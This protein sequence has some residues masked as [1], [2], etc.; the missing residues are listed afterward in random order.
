VTDVGEGGHLEVLQWARDYD[1]QWKDWNGGFAACEDVV[2]VG[3]SFP[4]G[5]CV[6]L[7]I[8][9]SSAD[10]RSNTREA[11]SLMYECFS[12]AYFICVSR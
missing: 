1:C 5:S 3:S 6:S 7:H 2:F 4:V 11:Y 8:V 10:P 9:S 12:G